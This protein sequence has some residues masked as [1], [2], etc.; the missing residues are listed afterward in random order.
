[1]RYASGLGGGLGG[2]D[3]P[4]LRLPWRAT[5]STCFFL[6]CSKEEKAQT[7]PNAM[8]GPAKGCLSAET[9]GWKMTTGEQLQSKN[10]LHCQKHPPFCPKNLRVHSRRSSTHILH[11]LSLSNTHSQD[12]LPIRFLW[13][14]QHG[15]ER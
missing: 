8:E 2:G 4:R 11:T 13:S 12:R 15:A 5:D 6:Q 7:L 10:K 14:G 3:K 9:C 1:M